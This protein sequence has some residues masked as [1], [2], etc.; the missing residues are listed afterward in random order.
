[1]SAT[2]DLLTGAS[3]TF[4]T[5]GF[6]AEVLDI[7]VSGISRPAVDSTHLGTAAAGAGKHGNAMF[8]AGRIINPGTVDFEINFNPDDDPPIAT[9]AET[10]TIAFAASGGDT[11]GAS[12]AGSGFMTD[13]AF[14]GGGVDGKMTGTATVQFSGNIT[15]TDGS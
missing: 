5:S 15:R 14:S 4:G 11:T 8:I 1:M 7:N 3:I 12:W 13:F 6:S 2:A 9:A 10:I